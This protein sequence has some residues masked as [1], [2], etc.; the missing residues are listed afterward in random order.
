MESMT[1]QIIPRLNFEDYNH[2]EGIIRNDLLHATIPFRPTRTYCQPHPDEETIKTLSKDLRKE[3]EEQ[4]KLNTE[5]E[6]CIKRAQERIERAKKGIKEDKEELQKYKNMTTEEYVR[7]H[8]IPG[9]KN[10]GRSSR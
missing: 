5:R 9:L 8:A 2:K 10:Q 3:W 1:Q 6:E 4:D 7:A